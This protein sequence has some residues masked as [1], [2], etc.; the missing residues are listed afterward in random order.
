MKLLSLLFASLISFSALAAD[1]AKLAKANDRDTFYQDTNYIYQV[2]PYKHV[3]ADEKATAALLSKS[4]GVFKNF[5]QR[6]VEAQVIPKEVLT[7]EDLNKLTQSEEQL[8]VLAR[9]LNQ[10]VDTQ[11]KRNPYDFNMIDALPDAVMIFGGAKGS[12]GK[13][14]SGAGSLSVG[15]VIMPVKITR[16]DKVTQETVS[17]Y[18]AKVAVVGMPNVDG[19]VGVGGGANFRAGLGFLWATNNQIVDPSQFVGGG[20]GLSTTIV[21]MGKGINLKINGMAYDNVRPMIDFIFASASFEFG[22]VSAVE[23]HLNFSAFIPGEKLMDYLNPS[24]QQPQG[25][26]LE[27]QVKQMEKDLTISIT[28]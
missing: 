10:W 2:S 8:D 16:I 27:E 14:V 15:L 20:M 25:G 22:V 24:K 12:V 21:P 5:L 26:S 17:Y 4:A 19:G 6:M 28:P 13:G 11:K 1:D 18:S 3:L 7:V 23:G 9:Y